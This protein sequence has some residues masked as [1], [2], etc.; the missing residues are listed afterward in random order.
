[1]RSLEEALIADLLSATRQL[2][3]RGEDDMPPLQWPEEECGDSLTLRRISSCCRWSASRR[4]NEQLSG[5]LASLQA[6]FEERK[7]IDKAKALLMSH[8][9]M[10][11]E[12]AGRRCVK[13]RWIRTSGWSK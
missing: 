1:M 2:L 11:E 10:Q 3:E 13:W 6:A 5:Q 7:I 4:G 12:Q 8:Q 9:G